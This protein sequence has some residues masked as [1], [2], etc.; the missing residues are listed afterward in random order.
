MAP[1]SGNGLYDT[2]L[3]WSLFVMNESEGFL[4]INLAYCALFSCLLTILGL[5]SIISD[6]TWEG[7]E[8][9]IVRSV[10]R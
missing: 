2:I 6:S 10:L 9:T 3:N 5:S 4:I 1:F 8:F 7:L